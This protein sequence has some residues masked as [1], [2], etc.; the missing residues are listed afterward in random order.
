MAMALKMIY[1]L[2]FLQMSLEISQKILYKDN[3]SFFFRQL[4]I[5]YASYTDVKYCSHWSQCKGEL[6]NKI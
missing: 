5:F 1:L 6:L 3:L 2:T 4:Q